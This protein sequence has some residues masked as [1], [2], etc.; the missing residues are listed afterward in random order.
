MPPERWDR[1]RRILAVRLDNLGDIVMTGPALRAVRQR[2]PDA[3]ITLL[4]SPAGSR[5]APLLPWL[6]EILPHRAVWQDA[7]NA[8]PLDPDREAA[9]I[10]GLRERAFDAALIFTSFSQSPWPPAYACYLAGIPIRVGH[11]S[12]FGGSLLTDSPAALPGSLHQV[13]RNIALVEAARIP[14]AG[15]DLE[16]V[17]PLEARVGADQALAALGIAPGQPFAL[18]AP[19]ASCAARRYGPAGFAEAAAALAGRL[20]M[21]VVLT[22]SPRETALVETIRLRASSPHVRSLGGDIGVTQL[23]A[24]VARAR[25]LVGNNSGPMHLADAVGCPMVILFSGTD[26]EEQWRPRRAPAV[27]LRRPTPCRP[28]YRFECPYQMEC[29]DIPPEEVVSACEA[30]VERTDRHVLVEARVD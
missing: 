18:V 21:P 14:V 22:G 8:L 13:D 28:C 3:H 15:R 30:V 9:F 17:P 6:D 5:A 2:C 11:S 10:G 7:S 16:I 27:L 26:L 12:D 4:A 29:L 19:G 1:V 24:V 25:L 20:S 23:A